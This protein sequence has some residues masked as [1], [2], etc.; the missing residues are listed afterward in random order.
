MNTRRGHP[1][2]NYL[3]ILSR[4]RRMDPAVYEGILERLKKQHYDVSRLNKRSSPQSELKKQ[5]GRVFRYRLSKPD[6]HLP[7][8]KLRGPFSASA[9]AQDELPYFYKQKHEQRRAG[10]HGKINP[11]IGTVSKIRLPIGV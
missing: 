11:D 2:R 3:W 10:R 8:L 4:S 7:K 5:A 1:K 9:A 6:P